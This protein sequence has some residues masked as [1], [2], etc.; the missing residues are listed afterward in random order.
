M[1]DTHMPELK[2]N[3]LV[4]ID[5][6]MTGLDY[7]NDSILEI[8]TIIT[9]SN[10]QVVATGPNLVIHQP[11]EILNRMDA[12]CVETHTKSGL[13]EKVRNSTLSVEQ[14]EQETLKFLQQYCEKQTAPLCGNTVWFDKLFL[15][16]DMPDIVGFLH[17][18]VVDVTA[19][20][21]ML[22]AWSSQNVSFKK[23]NSH[24][25]L[26]DILES[27]AELQY[28]RTNFIKIPNNQSVDSM[29]QD[30]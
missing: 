21:I 19:F 10:L 28:Y 1:K 6:E 16:K 11:E 3:L 22:S 20:K 24:R 7:F 29:Q 17:Y 9:D 23:Q 12:W 5:L 13:I 25:A 8:A 15:K 18:R 2:N 14:A 4:W 26:D 27:I 30:Q